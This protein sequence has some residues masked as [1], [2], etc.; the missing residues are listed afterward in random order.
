M[1]S[2][3]ASVDLP[4]QLRPWALAGV[5]HLYLPEGVELLAAEP[6]QAATHGPEAAEQHAGH[7]SSQA[8]SPATGQGA[9]QPVAQTPARDTRDD[10]SSPPANPQEWPEPWRTLAGRVRTKPRVIITYAALADDMSGAADPAR[11]KLFVSVLS[12][13]AWPQGTTLFWPISFPT[14]VDPGAA[15]ASDIFAAGVRHFG[16]K[17]L[18]CFGTGTAERAR[19]LYPQDEKAVLVHAAPAPQALI[20]LLPHELHQALAHLKALAIS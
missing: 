14:G 13:L 7:P 18:L 12:F 1:G 17:H 15:F 5:S 6:A 16:I 8:A 20:G 9:G 4:E 10:A 11:R 3:A 19:T 2:F